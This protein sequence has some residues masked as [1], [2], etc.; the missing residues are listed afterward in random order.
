MRRGVIVFVII[1]LFLLF[2]VSSAAQAQRVSFITGVA[3]GMTV[4]C[5]AR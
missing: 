3:T 4:R 1:A 5:A 2:F